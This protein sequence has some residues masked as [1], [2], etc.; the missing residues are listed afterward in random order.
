MLNDA[1]PI[2]PVDVRQ[3]N[4]F[5]VRLVDTHVDEADVV[6]EALS[7]HRGGDE[8]NDWTRAPRSQ[9]TAQLGTGDRV[10]PAKE[11]KRERLRWD[12]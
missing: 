10:L 1:G 6:V 8:R 7:E 4:G 3:R 5:L 2:H 11:K 9:H 12:G